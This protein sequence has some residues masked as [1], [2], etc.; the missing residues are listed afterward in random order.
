MMQVQPLEWLRIILENR[1]E[2]RTR[3]T[4]MYMCWYFIL[5][6]NSGNHSMARKGEN[7]V[8]NQ[9]NSHL[10]GK[11]AGSMGDV[12][13]PV[14]KHIQKPHVMPLYGV[15]V[16]DDVRSARRPPKQSLFL[17]NLIKEL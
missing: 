14:A 7:F 4:Y 16:S 10:C 15:L 13:Q 1:A 11:L 2:Q 17:G 9:L 5:V 8:Y 3:A 12:I 6:Q